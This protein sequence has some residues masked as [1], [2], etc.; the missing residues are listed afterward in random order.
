MRLKMARKKITG[1][2]A[3]LLEEKPGL[4]Q[5]VSVI[6]SEL[7]RD[8]NTILAKESVSMNK[9]VTLAVNLFNGRMRDIESPKEEGKRSK[10]VDNL[11][12]EFF[13]EK[14]GRADLTGHFIGRIPEDSFHEFQEIRKRLKLKVYEATIVAATL[15]VKYYKQ[16]GKR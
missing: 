2:L 11:L 14:K 4:E 10:V 8:F 13:D 15:L 1:S 16:H 12:Y 7:E 3:G 5:L 6:P 9:G